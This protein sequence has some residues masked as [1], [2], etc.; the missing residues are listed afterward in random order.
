MRLVYAPEA[1]DDLLRLREFIAE[2]DPAAAAR[3]GANLVARIEQLKTFPHMGIA[4]PEAAPPANVRDM[5]FGNYVVRYCVLE[6]ALAILRVWHHF[7][8]RD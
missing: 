4:V 3:I 6:Q 2:H 5:V 8:A 1:V 7:E